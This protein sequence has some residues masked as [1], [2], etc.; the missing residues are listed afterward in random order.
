MQLLKKKEK[1]Y[2][3]KFL[4]IKKENTLALCQCLCLLEE[5][6]VCLNAVSYAVLRT[7]FSASQK[8]PILQ[9]GIS[10]S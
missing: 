10:I 8:H 2:Y 4:Y 1:P 9:V 7:P 3:I 6:K 5:E